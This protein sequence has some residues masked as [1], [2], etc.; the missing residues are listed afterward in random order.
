MVEVKFLP[1]NK[2]VSVQ[3]GSNILQ[4][5]I[6]AEVQVESTCGGKG[7]CGKC[8]VRLQT[9]EADKGVNLTPA[10]KKFLTPAEIESG[11]VLA[12]QHILS[13]DAV[14]VLQE[15]KDAY[16]RKAGFH[17][18]EK[19]RAHAPGIRKLALDLKEPTVGDQGA[20][21][22][23]VVR[24]LPVEDVPFSRP[25]AASLPQKLRQGKF[26]VTAVLDG[27]RL[28]AVEPGD[29]RDRSYGLAI[30]IG[31]TTVVVYLVDLNRGTVIASGAVTNPQNIFGA[32][33]IARITHA[34]GGPQALQELQEKVVG[35]I[36][37]IIA[38]LT[39]KCEVSPE[40]IYQ[41]VVVGNT[42]MSHLFLGIDP[43]F[44]AP[45]PFI[46]AFQQAVEI[47]AG[48]LGLNILATA[49]VTVLPNVAGY[50]GSD[51]VGVMLAGGADRLQGVNLM[52]DIGTNGEIVL[53][54]KGSILTC[55]TAAGPA[56]E[57]AEIKHGMRAAEGAI[58]RVH[59]S[60]DVEVGVIGGTKPRGICGSGLIDALSEMV[61]V[62]VVESSGRLAAKE[63]QLENLPPLV[64]RRLRGSG[65]GAEFVLVWGE[66]SA[67]GEDLVISQKDV[68]ELQLAKGAI[69]AGIRV[70]LRELGAEVREI[71][72][73]FLA[74]AFGNYIGKQSALGI[75]LLPLVPLDRIAAIGNAAG[76]GAKMALLSVAEKE[77]AL[78]LA[79]QAR[80]IELSSDKGFQEEFIDA[81]SFEQK[82]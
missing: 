76:D 26:K 53:V 50:V 62:G 64:R 18:S 51:T 38:Q 63:A 21:W 39:G 14:V 23:R 1:S 78:S 48:E 17:D 81:L 75:G 20:D 10:E 73:V 52:V 40:E 25:V 71:D 77:R 22:E 57:G 30:D 44:L 2:T 6:A 54:G 47:E 12:C 60:S 37:G 79:R 29:T 4:A 7:T 3:D 69:M 66:D 74:G 70:L 27:V 36:N 11:W 16:D 58:E 82:V 80:H 43:S 49:I 31:T 24:A 19:I 68:R 67:T 65:G 59:I 35:G 13:E 8:K 9:G 55:S 56:F 46:P 42:T 72:R 34:A 41:A 32:D 15:Q 61:R 45:A 28:L 33:V 5:A